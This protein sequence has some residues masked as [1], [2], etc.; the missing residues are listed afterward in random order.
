MKS[1]PFAPKI[2]S[3]AILTTLLAACGGGGGDD[4]PASS[5]PTSSTI[6][7][8]AVKGLM[9]SAKVTAYKV[10]N[11]KKGDKLTDTTTDNNGAYTLTVSGYSGAVIL[12]MTADTNTKMLCDIPA[13]CE[14]GVAFGAATSAN[15]LVLQTVLGELKTT[16]KTAIT[17]FTHLAAKFAEKNGFNKTNIEIALTQIADLFGL[18]ALNETVAVN[19]AGNLQTANSAEQQYAIMNAAIAQLAGK[20]A[21]ISTKL[22]ALSAEINSKN[23]QLQSSGAAGFDLADV[24]AAAKDVAES[25]QFKTAVNGAVK[26]ILAAQLELANK[27]TDVTN[28]TPTTGAGLDDLA[29]AK[30]FVNSASLLLSTLQ[31][32]DDQSFIDTAANKVKAIQALTDG[33]SL[34]FDALGA[35]TVVMASAVEESQETRQ[36]ATAQLN[37]LFGN[38]FNNGEL[39]AIAS[40]DLRLSIDASTN[41]AVLNGEV[42]L[43]RKKRQYNNGVWTLVNDGTAK[44][45]TVT[46]FK[47]SYPSKT[48]T[49]KEFSVAI[50]A[51]SKIKT[52]NVEFGFASGSQSRVVAYFDTANTLQ[53]HIDAADDAGTVHTP[54]KVEAKLDRITL[55]VLNAPANEISQFVGNVTLSGKRLNLDTTTGGKRLWPMPD[56][57]TLSGKFSSADGDVVE[58]TASVAL[59]ETNP[60]VSP[61]QNFISTGFYNYKYDEANN[62]VTLKPQKGTMGFGNAKEVVLS[63]SPLGCLISNIGSV[64]SGYNY[65]CRDNSNVADAYKDFV[66]YTNGNYYYYGFSLRTMVNNEGVYIPIYPTNFDYKSTNAQ[67]D[68][69]LFYSEDALSENATHQVKGTITANTKI[70]LVGNAAADI[71]ALVTAN[72]AG[73][74]NGNLTMTVR[75]GEEK[76]D[77]TGTTQNGK[78]TIKLSNKNGVSVD[79]AESASDAN[80]LE[81]KVNGTVQGWVYKLNGAPV[82]KFTDNKL[83]FL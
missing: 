43:Q 73:Q 14:G 56:L 20:V 21:D 8:T 64:Q 16:N 26:T 3:A 78:T 81:L 80:K 75:A 25:N 36:L 17:P 7:G 65:G 6:T 66:Q 52:A 60:L 82:V 46:N 59:N 70:K 53:S 61:E 57:A 42:K 50:D 69:K 45:F 39:E 30:A 51:N 68:G 74:Q 2:L 5:T 33:D 41:T 9:Q 54:T 58:S 76:I 47:I 63:L 12:E 29:K 71:E 31:Q 72:Y 38:S 27:N 37:T 4:A 35:V 34:I 83:K 55:K 62:K 23:G 48:A 11:G 22:N 18:P 44:G 40:N 77:V 19:P 79:I 32:Y 67:V 15:G 13:G 28:A 24:L 1:L 10:V 49:A